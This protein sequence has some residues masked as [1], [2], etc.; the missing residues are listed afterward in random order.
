MLIRDLLFI[1]FISVLVELV[2]DK[3]FFFFVG[4]VLGGVIKVLFVKWEIIKNVL[5]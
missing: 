4:G 2:I 1:F 5:K 3:N